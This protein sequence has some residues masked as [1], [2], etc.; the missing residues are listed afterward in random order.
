M[1][2]LTLTENHLG[3]F[4]TSN[5]FQDFYK[6]EILFAIFSELFTFTALT[7]LVRRQ[8]EHPA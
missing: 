7:L 8:E 3:F 5:Q 4:K 2:R 1:C 6:P